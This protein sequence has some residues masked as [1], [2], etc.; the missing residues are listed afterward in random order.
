MIGLEK[1]Q[2]FTNTISSEGKDFYAPLIKSFG[3][4]CEP[5]VTPPEEVFQTFTYL[6]IDLFQNSSTSN[7]DFQYQAVYLEGIINPISSNSNY[8]NVPFTY[9]AK[10]IYED[11]LPIVEVIGEG[12]LNPANIPTFLPG[13]ENPFVEFPP[14]TLG[15]SGGEST[16][17][18]SINLVWN[19]TSQNQPLY[20][21]SGRYYLI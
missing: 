19:A 21:I 17:S 8:I 1:L 5:Q 10:I 3:Y 13:I 18:L 7:K 6:E 15:T 14:T 9:T 12:S 11:P 2:L 16:L 20:K 4:F